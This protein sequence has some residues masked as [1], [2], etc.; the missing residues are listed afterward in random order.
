MFPSS[1]LEEEI[2]EDT[3]TI[4]WSIRKQI[5]SPSSLMRPFVDHE[6]E[7]KVFQELDQVKR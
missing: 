6:T 1:K 2:E 3:K 7:S 5:S 4:P